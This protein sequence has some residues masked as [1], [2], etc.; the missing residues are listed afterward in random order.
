V[1]ESDVVGIKET[2]AN[3]GKADAVIRKQAGSEMKSKARLHTEGWE[4]VREAAGRARG[5]TGALH[6]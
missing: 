3:K 1:A 6:T 2:E 5:F 4:Q